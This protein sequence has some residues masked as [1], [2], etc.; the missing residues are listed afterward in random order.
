MTYKVLAADAQ[1]GMLLYYHGMSCKIIDIY[2]SE[3]NYEIAFT[4]LEKGRTEPKMF[5]MTASYKEPLHISL[6]HLLKQL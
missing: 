1:I 6:K 2:K 4:L 3:D 5:T